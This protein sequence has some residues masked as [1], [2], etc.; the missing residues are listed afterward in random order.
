MFN[1][2][3][4]N[5]YVLKKIFHAPIEIF[6]LFKLKSEISGKKIFILGSAPNPNLE[7]YSSRHVVVTINGS[8]ANAKE[9]GLNDSVMTVV[10]FELINKKVAL[11]KDVRSVIIKNNLLKNIDLGSVVAIQSNNTLLG[12]PK[13]LNANIKSFFSIHRLTRK[14]IIKSTSKNN[15]LDHKDVSLVSTGAFACALCFFL[16]AKEVVISGFS[17]LKEEN[18][19]PPSF[20]KTSELKFTNNTNKNA[21]YKIDTRSHSLADSSLI[22]LLVINGKKIK[23]GEK[24]VLPLTQNWGNKN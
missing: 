6:K 13:I 23:T 1:F 24:E 15:R 16:G 22:S 2:I 10:D 14:I 17:F 4:S 20:Y 7:L 21:D 3:L 11:D 5:K 18:F 8:A 12:D 9:L 19:H